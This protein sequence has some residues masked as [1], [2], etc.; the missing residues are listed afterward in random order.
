V[1]IGTAAAAALWF[2]APPP[3]G[4]RR[5]RVHDANGN[6]LAKSGAKILSEIRMIKGT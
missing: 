5:R 6:T 4:D 1:V 2:S 3:S